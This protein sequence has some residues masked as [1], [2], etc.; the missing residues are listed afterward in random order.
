MGFWGHLKEAISNIYSAKLRSI[1]AILGILVGTGSVVALITSSQL[2]TSHA[3]AQFK[4]LGTHLLAVN[5]SSSQTENSQAASQ[6][7][8]GKLTLDDIPQ[9]QAVSSQIL[10]IAP[11]ISNYL[12][13]IYHG[14]NSYGAVVGATEEFSSVA[15]V[16]VDK[17][18]FVRLFDGS[19]L[20]CVIGAKLAE[21]LQQDGMTNPIGQQVRLG[22]WY[23]TIIGVAKP[24]QPNLFV[25]TDIDNSVIIPLNASYLISSYASINNLLIKLS[26]DSNINQVQAAVQKKLNQLLP[27]ARV[28]IRNPEQILQLIGKQQRTFTWLLGAIGSISLL[29][30]GIGVMNIMLVSV[31]ERR[32]EIGVRLAIGAHQ[33][34]IL[35]MFL[36]E[37][38]M[39]TVLGGILGIIIGL[40]VSYIIA[41]ISGWEYLFYVLPPTLG[42]VVSV[43][44]GIV[45]GFYPA[46]RAS[47]LDPIESLRAE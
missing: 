6:E 47:R 39:L 9:I 21:K 19:S 42:F 7:N 30:G 1:L 31:V 34:D 11:Y 17:G 24:W 35:I 8:Q 10:Q 40:L 37:S 36:I 26:E 16:Y 27:N 20:Y 41:K 46:L 5:I 33:K 4:T 32:R 12:P 28:D 29:V 38:V 22:N 45:S 15:K 14:K 18:R 25:F 23:F 44:V 2:A 13:V 43:I 3:L